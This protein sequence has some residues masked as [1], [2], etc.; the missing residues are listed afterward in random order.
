M[1]KIMLLICYNL[2]LWGLLGF[3]ATLLLGFLSCCANL[4]E[5][6]FYTSLIIFAVVGLTSTAICVSKGCK[7]PLN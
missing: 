7:K 1:K 5:N 6:V 2:G 4:H 3:F